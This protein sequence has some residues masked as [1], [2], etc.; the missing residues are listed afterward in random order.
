VTLHLDVLLLM[1]GAQVVGFALAALASWLVLRW[2]RGC[3]DAKLISDQSLLVDTL[4]LIF[5]FSLALD[6]ANESLGWSLASFGAF[7]VYKAITMAG[8]A[9]LR[10]RQ[11]GLP[12]YRL[13]LLRVFGSRARSERLMA[14][15]GSRW[16]YVGPIQLIG[17]TDLVATTLEP[18]EF[19]DYV[20]G[21]LANRYIN[22]RERLER[23]LANLD[24][25]PD[26]DGRYRINE[27]LC[28]DDTWRMTLTRLVQ[29]SDAVLMDLRGFSPQNQGCVFELRQLVDVV[30]LAR[31][32]LI[33]DNT[34]DLPFLQRVLQDAWLAVAPDSP[35]RD[36]HPAQVLA[37]RLG[38]DPVRG[39][40][41]LVGGLARAATTAAVPQP[42]TRGVV[43]ALAVGSA[44]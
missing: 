4:W 9:L 11:G 10:R 20:R 13:L 28:H 15:V 33:V 43:P 25:A 1:L 29:T 41:T 32:V 14:L 19:L 36:L 26:A 37:Y 34:T 12:A 44:P 39:L 38:R 27:F 35:N 40:E 30:P 17:A 23:Q 3:Y 5:C 22:G 21:K 7:L 8:F 16:R 6:T 18:H 24:L 2:L 42:Q 31:V